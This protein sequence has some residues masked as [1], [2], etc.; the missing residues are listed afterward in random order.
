ME[1]TLHH[2]KDYSKGKEKQIVL[3]LRRR[4]LLII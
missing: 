2:V 1:K 4:L 3:W